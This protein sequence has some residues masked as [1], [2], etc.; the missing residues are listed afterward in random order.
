MKK[1]GVL[2]RLEMNYCFSYLNELYI[3]AHY[4]KIHYLV[5]FQELI[6]YDKWG[7][8]GLPFDKKVNN[9]FKKKEYSLIFIYCAEH[10]WV[11]F[12]HRNKVQ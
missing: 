1:F 11:C 7:T 2:Y 9:R 3:D 10:Y 4:L 8:L 5:H 12:V 6:N